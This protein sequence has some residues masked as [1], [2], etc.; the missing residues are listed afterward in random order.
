MYR[1]VSNNPV[2]YVDPTGLL[3]NIPE[4][5]GGSGGGPGG[6]GGALLIGGGIGG[7]IMMSGLSC[8]KKEEPNPRQDEINKCL[9]SKERILNECASGQHTGLICAAQKIRV[10][11]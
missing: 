5:G 6:G 11:L 3:Q 1:Y 4:G 8:P 9:E 10:C 2:R 7:A